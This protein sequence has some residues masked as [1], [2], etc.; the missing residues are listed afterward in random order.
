[1]NCWAQWYTPVVPDTYEIEKGGLSPGVQGQ[2]NNIQDMISTTTKKLNSNHIR[3]NK[4][5][6]H[7][8]FQIT[9]ADASASQR[10]I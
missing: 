10:E 1:L 8:E 6:S 2:L 4:Q 9:Y 7:L 3:E 5:I